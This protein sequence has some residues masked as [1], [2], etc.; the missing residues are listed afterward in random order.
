MIPVPVGVKIA[1]DNFCSE[2]SYFDYVR[3]YHVNHLKI[4]QSFVN[5]CSD[6]RRRG[7]HQCDC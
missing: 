2:Y 6:P 5:S 3:A 4:D 7:D 1:I